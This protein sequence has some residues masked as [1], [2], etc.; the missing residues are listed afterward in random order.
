MLHDLP[1]S[2]ST[3]LKGIPNKVYRMFSALAERKG[4]PRCGVAL[5]YLGCLEKEQYSYVRVGCSLLV[6]SVH[7][8]PAKVCSSLW[9][10]IMHS[11]SLTSVE[12][13]LS[14]TECTFRAFFPE[15]GQGYHPDAL[16]QASG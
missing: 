11:V 12:T 9:K 13:L 7:V 16:Y 15:Q 10:A 3:S 6:Q 4:P 2:F 8:F 5:S 14:S 1:F